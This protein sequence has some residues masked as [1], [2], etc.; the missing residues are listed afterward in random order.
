MK[1]QSQIRIERV[2][3]GK[4][5]WKIKLED[6]REFS[7]DVLF[8]KW[9]EGAYLSERDLFFLTAKDEVLRAIDK[10]YIFLSYGDLTSKEIERK[11]KER[12]F[13]NL[14]IRKTIKFLSQKSL[15][16]E[17]AIA[18]ALLKRYTENKPAG[19]FY[20]ERKMRER[21]ISDELV[22]IYSARASLRDEL[23]LALKLALVKKKKKNL[24]SILVN[25]GFSFETARKA[26]KIAEEEKYEDME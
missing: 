6:K 24:V 2:Y 23:S 26:A 13:S 19:A 14:S 15:L 9:K 1:I 11:L 5:D 21:G 8:S 10:A 18:E 17:E 22:K 7:T 3:Q 25:R 4:K 12:K 16:D 20:V